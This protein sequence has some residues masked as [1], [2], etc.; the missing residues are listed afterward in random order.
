VLVVGGASLSAA[1]LVLAGAA[2]ARAKWFWACLEWVLFACAVLVL[3]FG[4]VQYDPRQA[5]WMVALAGFAVAVSG[6]IHQR[7]RFDVGAT[8]PPAPDAPGGF[9]ADDDRGDVL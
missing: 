1:G 8:D 3:T 2:L 9:A 5:P 6:L 7:R 4:V